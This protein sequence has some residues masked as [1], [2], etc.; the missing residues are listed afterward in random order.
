MLFIIQLNFK[1]LNIICL[2][3]AV[4]TLT[5]ACCRIYVSHSGHM[6]TPAKYSLPAQQSTLGSGFLPANAESPSRNAP[7]LLLFTLSSHL[8]VR[9]RLTGELEL[10]AKGSSSFTESSSVCRSLRTSA[11]TNVKALCTKKKKKIN[12]LFAVCCVSG[13]TTAIKNVF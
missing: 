3:P 10:V 11:Q 9:L 12:S 5:H 7:S 8:L 6:A 4:C 1:W 13:E 2:S